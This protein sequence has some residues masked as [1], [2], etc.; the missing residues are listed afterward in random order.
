[1]NTFQYSENT[2]SEYLKYDNLVDNF[3]SEKIHFL[4]FISFVYSI[5]MFKIISTPRFHFSEVN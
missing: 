4:F 2:D 1:M 5:Y 3:C